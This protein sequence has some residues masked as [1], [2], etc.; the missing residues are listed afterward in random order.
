MTEL[1]QKFAQ[2]IET[3]KRPNGCPLCDGIGVNAEFQECKLCQGT[4]VGIRILLN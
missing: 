4:G 2:Y 3:L 1:E